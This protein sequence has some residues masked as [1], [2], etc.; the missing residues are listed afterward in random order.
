MSDTERGVVKFKRPV[1][2]E[3]LNAFSDGH[4]DV[5]VNIAE[6]LDR[7]RGYINTRL[8][9]LQDYGLLE[10]VGPAESSGLYQ[11]TPKGIAALKLQ[12]R[13]DDD[14]FEEQVEDRARHITIEDP[15]IIDEIGE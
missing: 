12:D 2:F 8:P 9:Q 3:I 10:R 6:R 11:I 13:Y 4:R 14:D 1:D 15:A 5:G 7:N